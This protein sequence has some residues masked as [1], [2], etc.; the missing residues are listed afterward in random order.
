MRK[1]GG[2][3][4]TLGPGSVW[5]GLDGDLVAGERTSGTMRAVASADFANGV[6]SVLPF[7]RWSYPS[8]DLTVALFREP[9]GA[10]IL[11]DAECWAGAEGRGVTHARLGYEGGWFGHSV[12]TTLIERYARA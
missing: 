3:F 12:Q 5:F 7:D 8:T 6:A 2:S 1:I 10:W 9:I 4:D 11:V